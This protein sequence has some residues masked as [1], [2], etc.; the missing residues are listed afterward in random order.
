MDIKSIL[1]NGIRMLVGSQITADGEV[2][3][4]T[5]VLVGANGAAVTPATLEGQQR[6]ELHVPLQPVVTVPTGAASDIASLLAA[7]GVTGGV[8]A[9]V[10]ACRLSVGKAGRIAYSTDGTA[11]AFAAG[12]A[13]HGAPLDGY[14]IGHPIFGHA[15]VAALQFAAETA[16]T[17][18]TIELLG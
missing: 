5:I 13:T 16:A 7:A 3:S 10:T 8:P 2:H 1:V 12:D 14:Y 11:P 18:V 17:K 15:A 6:H 4:A 9:W